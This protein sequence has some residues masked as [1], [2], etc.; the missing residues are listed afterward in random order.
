MEN[1]DV[2]Y[3][4]ADLLPLCQETGIP[5]VYDAHHH[6]CNAD[7]LSEEEAT[8]AALQTWNR[9]P[10]FHLSALWK[11]GRDLTHGGTMIL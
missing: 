10:M 2:T 6:R 5:L 7:D 4:P 11:A 9:E 1:D 3:T 8:Q